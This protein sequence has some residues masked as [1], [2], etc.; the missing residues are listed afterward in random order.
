MPQ[1]NSRHLYVL[2]VQKA[3]RWVQAIVLW[4]SKNLCNCSRQDAVLFSGLL[5]KR[6]FPCFSAFNYAITWNTFYCYL[7][8]PISHRS[9]KRQIL[10]HLLCAASPVLLI[11]IV[12][13]LLCSSGSLCLCNSP[14]NSL[15]CS[16]IICVV[17][18]SLLCCQL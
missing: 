12:L 1:G 13:C 16:P 5:R 14:N 8:H 9:V 7:H 3:G 4:K 6:H 15:P 10:C 11:R 18:T 17:L 2:S